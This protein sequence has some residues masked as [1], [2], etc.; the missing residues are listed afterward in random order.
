MIMKSKN[1]YFMRVSG[2]L[3]NPACAKVK[4]AL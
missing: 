1:R 4:K 2:V 3:M